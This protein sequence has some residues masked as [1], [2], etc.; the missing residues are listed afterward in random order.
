[1]YINK[2]YNISV[3]NVHSLWNRLAPMSEKNINGQWDF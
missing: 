1:M 2:G 3:D